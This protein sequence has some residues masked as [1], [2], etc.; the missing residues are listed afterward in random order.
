M[1]LEGDTTIQ[2]DIEDGQQVSSY[3][4]INRGEA[5]SYKKSRRKKKINEPTLVEE[6]I[7]SDLKQISKGHQ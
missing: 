2:Y 1:V 6:S 3:N 4:T 7:V 5:T